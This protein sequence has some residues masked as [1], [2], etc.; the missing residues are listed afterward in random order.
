MIS[1][2]DT[3]R[4][5]VVELELRN[6]GDVSI[7]VCGPTVYGPP[8]IGHGRHALVY[9]VLRRFLTW[10]GLDV[11]FVSNVT[12]IDDKI[13]QRASEERRDWTDIAAKC[14]A[15]WW[16]AMDLYDVERPDHTPHATEY[17]TEMVDL[18]GSLV[19]ADHAYRTAD[20]IYLRVSDVADY[21]LLAHQNLDD[22]RQGGGDRTL[23][24]TD[25]E[26]PADFAL[27]KFSKPG[28]PSWPSPWGEGRPGWH[29]ECVVMS[30]DL[31]GSGFDLHTG[32]LDL[33]FPHHEN[34]RAQAVAAGRGFARHWMHH[35]FVELGGEKMSKSL[36]N[37]TNLLDLA[38][39]FDPRA[40][41]LLVVQSHYR[42]PMEV[43]DV[44]MKN[45]EAALGR[46]DALARRVTGLSGTPD[47]ATLQ[48]FETVMSND[49]DTAGGADLMFRKTREANTSL[50]GGDRSAGVTAALTALEIAA[51]F[52]LELRSGGDEIP[53]DVSVLLARRSEARAA[54]DWGLADGIRDDLTA[55][56]WAVEDG[57]DGPI[58]RRM[59]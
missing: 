25:K 19:D 11:T 51:V 58:A 1:L 40:Y 49:L 46:L 35:G 12:D 15:V 54:G 43:T 3:A 18:I 26:H 39:A 31:L 36:G 8:H 38:D 52:G 34:E 9:D 50:D 23:V 17:V 14:E 53:A 7:Y 13:L 33:V 45:A 6:P 28:E 20:G 30:L 2:F 21:G 10:S 55:A 32:G 41:R 59:G 37:V 57:P 44:T 22:L 27:W 48:E 42:S 29:T 47:P 16:K 24:G 56:G 4:G 5:E